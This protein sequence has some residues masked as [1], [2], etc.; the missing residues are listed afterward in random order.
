MKKQY[1]IH[2]EFFIE[3]KNRDE[4]IEILSWDTD[5]I[6]SHVMVDELIYY[7]D[8]NKFY[9]E[10]EEEIEDLLEDFK[11]NCGWKS[12]NE[13]IDNLNG[14]SETMTQQKNLL[15]WFSFEEIVRQINEEFEIN[16]DFL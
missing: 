12:R 11:E 7:S 6:E 5:F 8:T 9:D 13:A 1:K 3:A 4:A 16:G 2:C 14:S 10:H 15:A